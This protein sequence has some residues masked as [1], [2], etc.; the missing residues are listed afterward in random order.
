MKNIPEFLVF[1]LQLLFSFLFLCV[2]TGKIK[3]NII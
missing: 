3:R 1:A 2:N